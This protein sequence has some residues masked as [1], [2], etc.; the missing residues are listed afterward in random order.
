MIIRA[1]TFLA[2]RQVYYTLSVDLDNAMPLHLSLPLPYSVI[3]V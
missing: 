3:Q 1:G 2:R